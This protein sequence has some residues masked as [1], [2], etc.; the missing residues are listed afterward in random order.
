MEYTLEWIGELSSK[1]LGRFSHEERIGKIVQGFKNTAY[2]KTL[3]DELICLTSY[4]IRAPTNLNFEGELDFRNVDYNDAEVIRTKDGLQIKDTRFIMCYN[5]RYQGKKQF[6]TKNGVH[7]RAL[8]AAKA[9]SL[10]DLSGS[11]LDPQCPFFKD[12]SH[13]I[14]ALSNFVCN[15]NFDKVQEYIPSLIGLGNVC[16]LFLVRCTKSAYFELFRRS[17]IYLLIFILKRR[18]HIIC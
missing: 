14:K 15:H 2:I 13:S 16:Y 5:K 3:D 8:F 6:D 11:L 9:L 4:P 17:L 10:L 18:D 12:L 1:T 7:L